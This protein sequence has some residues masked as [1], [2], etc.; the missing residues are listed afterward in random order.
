M[1]FI[2][3]GEFLAGAQ[4]EFSFFIGHGLVGGAFDI[5]RGAFQRLFC[6]GVDDGSIE[7]RVDGAGAG[8]W[9]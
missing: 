6:F 3:E 5:D 7:D 9:A 4:G 8:C 1:T 2:T